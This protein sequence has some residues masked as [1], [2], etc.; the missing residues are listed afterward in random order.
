MTDIKAIIAKDKLADLLKAW[1]A[2]HDV[3]VPA[4]EA[5][6]GMTM[7][8]GTDT[9]F[10]ERYRNTAVPPKDRF[11]PTFED[12]FS[13]RTS[14]DG[15]ILETP[16]ASPKKRLLFGIRPCDAAALAMLDAVFADTYRDEYYLSRRANTI[17][18]GLGCV[19]PYDSCFCTSVGLEPAASADVDIMLTDLGDSY[20]AEGLSDKGRELLTASGLPAAGD[21]DSKK[22][23][24]AKEAAVA[25]I[26]R[27]I[28]TETVVARLP[29]VFND[30]ALW[31]S[32]AAKCISCGVCTFLCPTCY[33]FDINDESEGNQ[34]GRRV[35][36]WDSCSFSVYTQMPAENPREEKWQRVR[37]KVNHKYAFYPELFGRV[38]CTGC[39]RC[40]RQCPVNWDITRVLGTLCEKAPVTE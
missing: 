36:N 2:S 19:N 8:D 28:D 35:R 32:A 38:A 12:M 33:C 18:V 22:A 29:Q 10:L 3:F 23:E 31:E 17:T 9:A 1:Q 25:K 37:Q 13:F 20:L 11:L 40:I 7:W 24:A 15:L 14:E 27:K 26:T 30:K 34:G 21:A 4:V 16:Q 39:G 6:R 5:G